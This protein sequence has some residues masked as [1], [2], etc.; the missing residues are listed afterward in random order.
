VFKLWQQIEIPDVK[1]QRNVQREQQKYTS[2]F[3]FIAASPKD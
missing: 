1:D 2:L 3:G